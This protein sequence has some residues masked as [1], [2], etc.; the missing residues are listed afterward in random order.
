MEKTNAAFGV[1]WFFLLFSD[2]QTRADALY[3]LLTQAVCSWSA[4]KK[5][6]PPSAPLGF[7]CFFPTHKPALTRFTTC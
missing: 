3:R 1:A 6:M 5:Q 4:W 7:S 2:S